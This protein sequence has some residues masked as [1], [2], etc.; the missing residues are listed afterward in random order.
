MGR[1]IELQLSSQ[2]GAPAGVVWA[3]A[4]S[5]AGVNAE[6]SPWV[7]MTHPHERTTLAE[8]RHDEL[9]S[10]LFASWLL[11]FGM[12]PFDRHSLVLVSVESSPDGGGGFVEQSTSWLQRGWRHEREVVARTDGGCTV[13]D[14]LVVEPRVGLAAPLVARVVRWLFGRRHRVLRSRFTRW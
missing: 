6:L 5:M 10:V 9:G 12:L 4:S 11:A 3:H 14:R 8:L 1:S 7:R 2:L 13:T